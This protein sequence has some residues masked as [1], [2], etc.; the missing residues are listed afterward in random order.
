MGLSLWGLILTDLGVL[1]SDILVICQSDPSDQL[2]RYH[3]DLAWG[4][5]TLNLL[6]DQSGNWYHPYQPRVWNG[7]LQHVLDALVRVAPDCGIEGIF[8][9]NWFL[10]VSLRQGSKSKWRRWRE[11][12]EAELEK[13][14]SE[15]FST[16]AGLG[17]HYHCK[18]TVEMVR[19]GPG[20]IPRMP[21]ILKEF[22]I[23]LAPEFAASSPASLRRGDGC[24]GQLRAADAAGMTPP[25]LHLLDRLHRMHGVGRIHVRKSRLQIGVGVAFSENRIEH[26]VL[27]AAASLT[28]QAA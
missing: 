7:R 5:H 6:P 23:Q 27:Q 16:V 28:A 25:M 10:A 14:M 20:F 9:R 2:A 13:A 24:W 1:V 4:D 17:S 8:L 15:P 22:E 21:M 3:H 12:Y 18:V 26:Q 11:H 19:T